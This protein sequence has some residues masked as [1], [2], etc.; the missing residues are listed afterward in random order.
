MASEA[1]VAIFKT[2]KVRKVI[3]KNEWWFSIIDVVSA[4]TDSSI[5]KRYW[6]DLKRKLEQE[7]Y[8]EVYEKIVRL[9]M[10]AP[11]G[12]M[13]DTDAANT[14]T[15]FRII[16]SIPSPKAEPFKLWLARGSSHKTKLFAN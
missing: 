1:K 7:G 10:K 12:K 4:L 13:R 15:L 8:N 11:D 5:P 14:E 2:K 16:Q 3:H 9:K 6:T